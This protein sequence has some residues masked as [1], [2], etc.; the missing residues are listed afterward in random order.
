LGR[1]IKGEIKMRKNK[2]SITVP[3]FTFE[4]D[5]FVN[6]STEYIKSTT[7]NGYKVNIHNGDHDIY[8][9]FLDI[10]YPAIM[11]AVKREFKIRDIKENTKMESGHTYNRCG[12]TSCYFP[13]GLYY[14][15]KVK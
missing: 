14:G 7:G 3:S 6:K 11:K 5:V 12:T 2:V 4:A 13:T 9:K 8:H 10:M 15:K 1:I